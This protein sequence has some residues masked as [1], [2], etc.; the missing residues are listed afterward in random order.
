VAGKT[1]CAGCVGRGNIGSTTAVSV[2]KR[3]ESEWIKINQNFTFAVVYRFRNEP[4]PTPMAWLGHFESLP[5]PKTGSLLPH[6]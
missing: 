4:K 1:A 6:Y 3:I 2:I 5:T